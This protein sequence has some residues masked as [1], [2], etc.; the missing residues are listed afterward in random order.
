MSVESLGS[1]RQLYRLSGVSRTASDKAAQLRRAESPSSDGLSGLGEVSKYVA[2]V[3]SQ[4][5]AREE[6]VN[7][8]K[9][10]I[11]N[12]TYQVPIDQLAERL[13][14]SGGG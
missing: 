12:G 7:A 4:P 1:A 13:V 6:R 8:L 10:Q 14:G 9:A 2:S 3:Q 11:A 5:S